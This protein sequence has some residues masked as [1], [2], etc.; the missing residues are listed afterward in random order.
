MTR[1]GIMFV[2]LGWLMILLADPA[3]AACT[4]NTVLMPDGSMRFCQTCCTGNQCHT[5]CI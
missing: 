3:L 4:S 2:I 1:Y 5:T